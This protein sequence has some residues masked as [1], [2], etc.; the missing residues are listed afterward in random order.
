MSHVYGEVVGLLWFYNVKY[1]N[2]M[3]SLESCHEEEATDLTVLH[4]YLD[5]KQWGILLDSILMHK[6]CEKTATDSIVS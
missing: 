6:T 5:G 2:E 4:P 3:P 1:K